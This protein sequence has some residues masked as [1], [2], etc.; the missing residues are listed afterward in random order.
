MPTTYN[1]CPVLYSFC[2]RIFRSCMQYL[3]SCLSISSFSS[4]LI[5]SIQP[6]SFTIHA[7]LPKAQ[8]HY[9]T[10]PCML[11]TAQIHCMS[12]FSLFYR[13]HNIFCI[14]RICIVHLLPLFITPSYTGNIKSSTQS[15]KTTS[16]NKQPFNISFMQS[17]PF[18]QKIS[19]APT[20]RYISQQCTSC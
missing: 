10:Y 12:L 11:S 7:C 17:H 14:H 18:L 16:I 20:C 8:Y 2:V 5:S 19:Q 13:I 4:N 15:T 3:Q 1:F 6:R 9:C